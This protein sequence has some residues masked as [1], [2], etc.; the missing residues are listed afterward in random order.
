MGLKHFLK[1]IQKPGRYLKQNITQQGFY[2]NDEASPKI[3][4]PGEFI[5]EE[6][7]KKYKI[8]GHLFVHPD[9]LRNTGAF[10]FA[11]KK[12]N[13][14]SVGIIRTVKGLGDVLIL[15][16]IGK[17]LKEQYPGRVKVWFAVHPGHEEL[18]KHNPYIDKIFTSKEK[19]MNEHPDVHINVND[20]E[21]KTEIRDEEKIVCNRT[22]LYLDKMGLVVEDKTPYYKI[23]EEEKKFAKMELKNLGYHLDK[24]IIGIQLYGSNISKTYPHMIKVAKEL[25]QQ[26]YQIF[27]LDEKPY[28]YEIR[29]IA[30]IV[31]ETVLIITPNSFFYHL[32]GALRKRAIALFGYTDGKVWTE[33]Y[34]KVTP[35]Q[36]PCPEGRKR[37]W[38]KIECIPGANLHE[39]ETK[40]TPRCL[41]EIPIRQ[42]LEKVNEHLIGKKRILVVM[43]TYNGIEMTKRAVDSIKSFHDYDIFIIDNKSSDGTPKWLQKNN[44]NYVSKKSTVAEALNIGLKKAYDEKYDY[45]LVCNNDIILG[46]NY[47][48]KVVEVAERRQCLAVSGRIINKGEKVKELPPKLKTAE[49][50]MHI[51][52][53]GSF[54]AILLSQKCLEVIGK[55]DERYR[56]RYQEDDDYLLR[57]RLF[58][59]DL[60]YTYSTEFLHLLGQ[61]VKSIE[62]EKINQV[63]DWSRN[64]Q[65]YK[66]K[67]GFDPYTERN[68]HLNLADIKRRCPDWEKKILISLSKKSKP[69][70]VKRYDTVKEII[71]AAVVKN[72]KA[73]ALIIRGMGGAGDIIFLSIIARA[74][75]KYHGNKIN[76]D[77]AIPTQFFS[78]LEEDPYIHKIVDYKT[79]NQEGYDFILDLTDYEYRAELNQVEKYG[80]I[81]TARTEFY[82]NFIKYKDDLKPDYFVSKK[83]VKLAE[84]EWGKTGQK[85]IG[86]VFEGSN[87]MKS[88]HGMENLY[89]KLIKLGYHVIQLDEKIR[90]RYRYNF[91][92]MGA[93]IATADLI[94]SPDTGASNQA[95]ALNIPV[96]TIF[97]NR[98][99]KNFEKMF[100]SMIAVQGECPQLKENY[101]DYKVP[102]MPGTIRQYR[103]KE[104]IRPP[105]CFQNLKVERVLEEI[106]KVLE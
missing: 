83:E 70:T 84:N 54:S 37:C 99:G 23:T 53:A 62:K 7:I 31:N 106:K 24:P 45:T 29:E 87:L 48:D 75:K 9:S 86:M 57:I 80:E 6:N 30:A 43:L 105:A 97:S 65:Q 91:R 27:Y 78:I 69:S 93:V 72:G 79:A 11:A 55:F 3:F 21:F 40:F 92:Q 89:R 13:I 56:P 1:S 20:L 61:V 2:G 51:T 101:C 28:R 14:F 42:V 5:S 19:L 18:L 82:L 8:P 103:K 25:Q 50:P 102:C 81:K 94:I 41:A 76:I 12:K 68:V 22:A 88:W 26:G 98:N 44:I 38:W 100:K 104:S 67:W 32:A 46:T 35:L 77:Y 52:I 17:A 39:K 96:I 64:V 74:L 10:D 90:D 66:K 33:D 16:V 15:S 58:E 47:I 4:K 59:G 34:E 63:T 73:N 71:E 60:I 85:R 36:I 49:S 95:G